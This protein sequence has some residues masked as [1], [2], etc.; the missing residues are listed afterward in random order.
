[1]VVFRLLINATLVVQFRA[2]TRAKSTLSI[3]RKLHTS[4]GWQT[5]PAVVCS[6]V[7]VLRSIIKMYTASYCHIFYCLNYQDA[8]KVYFQELHPGW[9]VGWL[10]VHLRLQV[11]YCWRHQRCR[12]WNLENSELFPGKCLV[13]EAVFIAGIFS[14]C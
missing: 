14:F 4:V 9:L 2:V 10:V 8:P 11:V 5:K 6:S 3:S 7:Y 12:A 13:T 1:M